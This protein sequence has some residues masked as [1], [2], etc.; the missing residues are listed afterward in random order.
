MTDHRS[1]IE[2][3]INVISTAN[4]PEV[5]GLGDESAVHIYARPVFRFEQNMFKQ[6]NA[7]TNNEIILPIWAQI[8][9]A[10]ERKYK[11]K[12]HTRKV[13]IIIII[14]IIIV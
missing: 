2:P 13:G 12:I 8:F 6:S 4:G 10:Q 9:I 3:I 7:T 11:A 5:V 14:I 1:D